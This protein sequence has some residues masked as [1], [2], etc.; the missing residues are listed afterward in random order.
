MSRELALIYAI[1]FII[2]LHLILLISVQTSDVTEIRFS[3]WIQTPPKHINIA[4]ECYI[5]TEQ[6]AQGP[7]KYGI[8]V[9]C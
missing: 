1:S 3:P 9:T 6:A 8:S 5:E 2:S 7:G 4:C